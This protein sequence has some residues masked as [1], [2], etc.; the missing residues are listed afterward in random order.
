MKRL[1]VLSLVT[2]LFVLM[3]PAPAGAVVDEIVGAWCAG[4]SLQPPGINGSLHEH[5]LAQ[6]LFAS[7]VIADFHFDD[8]GDGVGPHVV[9]DFSRPN[10]KIA[11]LGVVIN[12]DSPAEPFYIDA[13]E[14]KSDFPAFQHC[15]KLLAI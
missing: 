14:L 1:A 13:F 3:V 9:F 7:G 10:A 5:N 12:V 6:P 2:A 4:K 8:H 11:S 15:P